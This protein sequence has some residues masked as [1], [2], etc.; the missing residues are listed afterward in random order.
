M[1]RISLNR[2]IPHPSSFILSLCVL[3]LSGCSGPLVSDPDAV[4]QAIVKDGV[5]ARNASVKPRRAPIAVG[6]LIPRLILSDQKGVD[7]S[8][9]EVVASGDAVLVFFPGADAPEARALFQWVREM[10]QMAAGRRCEILLVTP[11]SAERNAMIAKAEDLH[12]AMLT[13]PSGWAARAFGLIPTPRDTQVG[14]TW[15]VVLGREG[16]VMAVRPGL[17]PVTDLI[18]TL[19]VRPSGDDFGA[20]DLMW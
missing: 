11:D 7:V 13:D 9:H 5:D 8:T 14:R 1:I 19:E 18:T 4:P 16:R 10:R 6:E 15:S 3:L 2:L 20:L 12:V 17:M